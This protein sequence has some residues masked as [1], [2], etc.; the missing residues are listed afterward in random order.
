MEPIPHSTLNA[1]FPAQSQK[2][3]EAASSN[4]IATFLEVLYDLQRHQA[5]RVIRT[6]EHFLGLPHDG[7]EPVSAEAK[8]RDDVTGEA[9]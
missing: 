8:N 5:L 2:A 9:T 4:W 7:T 1:V 3:G 6:Y